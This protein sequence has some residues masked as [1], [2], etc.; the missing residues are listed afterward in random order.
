[1]K[2]PVL[3]MPVFPAYQ[4][5]FL[6]DW[7]VLL[8]SSVKHLEFLPFSMSKNQ[9]KRPPDEQQTISCF[10]NSPT[11]QQQTPNYIEEKIIFHI[12]FLLPN[13]YWILSVPFSPALIYWQ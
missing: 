7:T 12:R 11:L 1:M 10:Q 8:F 13:Y 6:A 2:A 9:D 4:K 5:H 3:N